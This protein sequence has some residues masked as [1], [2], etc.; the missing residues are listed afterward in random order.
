M[1]ISV[2]SA[3]TGRD[4]GKDGYYD[5]VKEN[6][7]LT[8]TIKANGEKLQARNL[9]LYMLTAIHEPKSLDDLLPILDD[10]SKDQHSMIIRYKPNNPETNQ[11]LAR[12][13][14]NFTLSA[15]R[16]VCIDIDSIQRPK[17]INKLDLRRQGDYVCKLLHECAP[18]L[19]PEDLG[20]IAQASSSAGFSEDIKLHL[21]FENKF[22]LSQAQI[23]EIFKQ[24][25]KLHKEKY[26]AD[27]PKNEQIDFVDLALFSARQPH[28][29]A[30]PIIEG[31]DPFFNRDRMFY[32][33]GSVATIN[34]DIEVIDTVK[35]TAQEAAEYLSKIDG[36]F[37]PSNTLQAMLDNLEH[38]DPNREGARIKVIAIYHNA[39]QECFDLDELDKL[40]RV[41]LGKIRPGSEDE[42]IAQGRNAAIRE[43]FKNSK[44]DLPNEING[45]P[46]THVDSNK[47]GF[48]LRG[49]K[50]PKGV[51]FLK[52][53]LGT[54]KTTLVEDMLRERFEGSFLSITN[55]VALVESN[56]ARF[57]SG[58]YN[59][60][61]TYM[62]GD[63]D[64]LRVSST[65]HSLYRVFKDT[66][67]KHKYDLVFIDECDA[68]MNDLISS[69]VI[70]EDLK[71][72]IIDALAMILSNSDRVILSDGDISKETME[73]YIELL[74]GQGKFHKVVHKRENLHEGIAFKHKSIESLLGAMEGDLD[75]SKKCLL[76]SDLSPVKLNGFLNTF[77]RIMPEKVGYVIHAN[78]KSDPSTIDIINN[79]TKALV[80]RK[81][82]YLLCSP[83]I[84]NG[85]DFKYFDSIFVITT[86]SNHSPNMRFQA[87]KRERQGTRVNYFIKRIKPYS[88]GYALLPKS[89]SWLEHTRSIYAM[90][91][92]REC[93]RYTNTFNHYLLDAGSRIS[94]VDVSYDNPQTSED[95]ERA[96][97]DRALA[98]FNGH[99][100]PLH[101]DAEDA[102]RIV[103]G[104]L[105][106]DFSYDS[107]YSFLKNRVY[108]RAKN[109][110]NVIDD[111]WY[112]LKPCDPAYLLG[113]LS[114]AKAAKFHRVSGL[115]L[116]K[117]EMGLNS[118]LKTCSDILDECNLGDGDVEFA[119][120]MYKRYCEVEEL[121]INSA[122]VEKSSEG[123]TEL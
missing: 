26:Q 11:L 112:M 42:Y 95:K 107:V 33:P 36:S 56:A 40:I 82:D 25:N 22:E 60:V 78:S 81:V 12:S 28:Y 9:G 108:E 14:D 17:H 38:W 32:S 87:L 88:S 53:S 13:Q 106:E 69:S 120:D 5:I 76:V 111:Y 19:F 54:G 47:D 80:R 30:D 98:V 23:R 99:N 51:T 66:G 67:E 2:L 70:K 55:T 116:P 8:K 65:I 1:T 71:P 83:S 52:A 91:K 79:T 117:P 31:E 6:V 94:V 16:V 96:L 93:L 24:I 89:N 59:D 63:D 102:H 62:T 35:V 10:L 48:H 75:L 122:F 46:I 43:V 100:V 101:N 15:S 72:L 18:G 39:V 110:A 104:F 29:L 3:F 77:K 68:V 84:T 58:V 49:V 123:I 119:I 103:K 21:W 115:P 118:K 20:F 121:Q 34:D 50:V 97:E 113:E 27:V 64:T 7:F 85:V 73:A 90:R 44:R 109:L 105:K 92:E 61:S 114:T 4:K 41:I 37:T 45:V 86:T 74:N 57:N